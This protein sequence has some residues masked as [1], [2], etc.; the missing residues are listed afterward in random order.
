MEVVDADFDVNE[1]IYT[2]KDSKYVLFTE[3]DGTTIASCVSFDECTDDKIVLEAGKLCLEEAECTDMKYFFKV[4]EDGND[5]TRYCV[6][7]CPEQT[8]AHDSNR[9][10]TTC[11]QMMAD[12][13]PWNI[14]WD[15]KAEEC[16]NGCEFSGYLS[17]SGT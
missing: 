15:A 6:S 9:V 2:C 14:Y 16:I 11:K 4:V 8:P 13:Y 3:D 1:N 5:T 12:L 7:A 10:C 17:I